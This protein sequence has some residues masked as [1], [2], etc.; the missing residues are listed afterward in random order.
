MGKKEETV[1]ASAVSE[2]AD[3]IPA[4]EQ[5]RK[6][7]K[8][9]QYRVAREA[10]NAKK[11]KT[12][13]SEQERQIRL[14]VEA[15]ARLSLKS[16]QK[17]EQRSDKFAETDYSRVEDVLKAND[18]A[19]TAWSLAVGQYQSGSSTL[20]ISG[21]GQQKYVDLEAALKVWRKAAFKISKDGLGVITRMSKYMTVDDKSKRPNGGKN[22]VNL[23]ER[24]YQANFLIVTDRGEINVHIDSSPP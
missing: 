23:V 2:D 22:S 11:G 19:L 24:K 7:R 12:P 21:G 18:I 9:E 5:V 8:E 17:A 10:K 4:K 14:G 15:E 20:N 1:S 16:E 13:E 3:V 6:A